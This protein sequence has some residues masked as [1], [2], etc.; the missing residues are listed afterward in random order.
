MARTLQP[1]IKAEVKDLLIK[2]KSD[3]G[4]DIYKQLKLR[5]LHLFRPETEDTFEEDCLLV[6][7]GKPSQPWPRGSY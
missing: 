2:K 7:T 6:L 3:S 1:Q 5:L 4:T